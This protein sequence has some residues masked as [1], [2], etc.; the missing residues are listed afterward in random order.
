[1]HFFIFVYLHVCI[2]ICIFIRIFIFV[3]FCIFLLSYLYIFIFSHAFAFYIFCIFYF[4]FSIICVSYD[5]LLY[6]Y[7]TFVC[8]YVLMYI[9]H[10]SVLLYY[11]TYCG[12]CLMRGMGR[13]LNGQHLIPRVRVRRVDVLWNKL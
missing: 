5:V 3:Y 4:N 8:D 12:G 2:Y 9:L 13:L 6:M 10:V 11:P 7:W 1:M